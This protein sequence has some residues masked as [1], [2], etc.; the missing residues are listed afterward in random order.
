MQPKNRIKLRIRHV[1]STADYLIGKIKKPSSKNW[2]AI[3]DSLTSYDLTHNVAEGLHVVSKNLGFP[4]AKMSGPTDHLETLWLQ[5]ADGVPLNSDLVTIMAGTNDWNQ[6][7]P[8]GS[9]GDINTNTYLGAYQTLVKK[10]IS[11]KRPR[12]LVLISPPYAEPNRSDRH[13][14][15]DGNYINHAGHSLED[16]ALAVRHLAE[17]LGVGFIDLYRLCGFQGNM[18]EF[19]ATEDR[20]HPRQHGRDVLERLL[21]DNL[22]LF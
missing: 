1:R 7:Q 13:I 11:Q 21:V 2:I 14:F 4:G 15:Q 16:Y 18:H 22:R 12:K 5:V 9:L 17:H 20:I 19:F 6:G 8:I 3:G 10:I